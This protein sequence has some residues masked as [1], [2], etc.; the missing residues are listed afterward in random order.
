MRA[1]LVCEEY[2]KF[3]QIALTASLSSIGRA[4]RDCWS[5]VLVPSSAILRCLG[6]SFLA[7]CCLCKGGGMKEDAELAAGNC[8]LSGVR[9]LSSSFMAED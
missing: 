1:L 2:E 6:H 7:G 8:D 9:G 3:D 4:S 5:F